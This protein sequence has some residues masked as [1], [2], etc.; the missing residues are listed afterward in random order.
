M[1]SD[2][3]SH[4]LGDLSRLLDE[5]RAEPGRRGEVVELLDDRNPV[6]AGRSA[7][8]VAQIRGVVMAT[9]EHTGMSPAAEEFVAEELDTGRHPQ[10]VAAAAAALRGGTPA[11]EWEPLLLRALEN[12]RLTDDTVILDQLTPTWPATAPTTTASAQI[13]QTLAWLRTSTGSEKC[14]RSGQ[15]IAPQATPGGRCSAPL[16]LLVQDQDGRTLR[17]DA[18]LADAFTVVVLFYTRCDNPSKCSASITNLA[19]LQREICRR[20]LQSA[21]KTAAITYDP[22][23]DVPRRLL[24]YGSDRGLIFDD[25]NRMVRVVADFHRLSEYLALGV[26]YG[27]VVPNRHRIELFV[28]D[29]SARIVMTH[30][31]L[32]WS[33]DD[34]A[35][36]LSQLVGKRP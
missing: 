3:V 31:R 12:V 21:V 14:C 7:G 6:Y 13:R 34:V 26:S 18:L 11:R 10:V 30:T 9:L 29:D 33:P 32:R 15:I 8:T 35:N 36:G 27:P 1:S 5:I 23:Y 20:K 17:L 2:A 22:E 19:S 24:T 16:D 28:L 25:R 4:D